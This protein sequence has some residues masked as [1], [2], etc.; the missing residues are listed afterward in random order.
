MTNLYE[1]LPY[2]L[3][4]EFRGYLVS[5]FKTLNKD[6]QLVSELVDNHKNQEVKA[7]TSKQIDHNGKPLNQTVDVLSGRI[8]NQIYGAS[9]NS[10][11]EVKDIRV[12][13]DGTVHDLA[14]DRLMK[15]FAK[16]DDVATQADNMAQKHEGQIK[17]SAYYNE[18]SYVSGRKFDTTYK[19]VHIPHRDSDGNLIKLRKGISGSNPS[20]PDH[21]T[22]RDFAK[23]TSATFVANASTGSGSQLKLHGQQIYN[24]QILDSVKEYAPLKDR[25]TLAMAD[26][27]T[28]TSFPPNITAKEIKDKGYNN[29][30][31]GFGPLIMEGKK[32]YT[33]GDYSPNSEVS[34]PRTVIAQLP[35]KDIL[36]FTCD[37]RI[38]GSTLHQKGMTLNEVTEVLYSH[39]GDIEFAYNLDGGGSSSAVLRSRMLN[40]PSDNNNKSER[41][42]L[43]FI[44]VGKDPRQIRD[45]DIQKAYEDIGDLRNNF[46]FLYGLLTT[47]NEVN[48]NEL[49]IRNYNDYTGIVAM[50]GENAKKK[51][52]M[53]PNE[54]RF[55]DYD[56][57]RTWLRVTEDAMQ[58]HNRELADNFSAP[59]SV[60][61][62]NSLQRGGTYHVPKNAKGSPYPNASSAIVTQYNVTYASFDDAATSFQTAVP[63]ARSQNYRM[64]RRTYAEGKWSQW[65]DV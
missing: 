35:N 8:N 38:T 64:K 56:T 44:Y 37:G 53:Q 31:S 5:N 36:I 54:F 24:G 57:S 47:W 49:R 61:D 28:L 65:Y 34:H 29:T 10:S 30:F 17:E 32:V 14:Q 46:Q 12:G 50:D 13:M 2:S 63:F 39:Y 23:Q 18:I 55:W 33:E 51:F 7:H 16:I 42:L 4:N 1:N 41:K 60:K 15:D 48:S 11:A 58:L 43:D 25:W 26:D 6:R 27:N 52:Y 9:K 19:I 62:C 22:A 45:K 59:R 20:K 21:I 3:N 40:K